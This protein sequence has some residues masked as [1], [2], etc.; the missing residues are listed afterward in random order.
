MSRRWFPWL[1]LAAILLVTALVYWPGTYGSWALDDY[2]NIVDNPA[3][4]IKHLSAGALLRA[5]LSMHSGIFARPLAMAS[6][7]LN[8]W[9]S[10]LEPGPMKVT[11]VA[12]HL[13]NGVLV[14]L[15]VRLLI[16]EYGRRRRT[17]W[18]PGTG[19]GVALLITAAWLLTPLNLTAVLYIV[20][21]MTSLAATFTL[22]ALLAYVAGRQRL[23]SG[24]GRRGGIALLLLAAI[25]LTPLSVSAKEVGA[26]TLVYALV[27]EWVFFGFRNADGRRSG[28]LFGYF[29]LF[30]VVPGLLGA[31][32][33][34]PIVFGP[35]AYA[36]RPFGL[37]E[38]LLTEGRVLWHYLWWTLFPDIGQLSLYHDA[39][40]VSR[41]LWSP[42]STLPAWIGIT[43]LLGAGLA[44][45]RRWPLVSFGILWFL[46]G[47]LLT[48]TVFPLELVFEHRQYL[49]SLGIFTS[50]FGSLMLAEPRMRL[51]LARAAGAGAIVLLYAGALALRS[52]DWS[53]PLIMTN[54][55]AKDHPHSPRATYSYA[56]V[57]AVLVERDPSLY[58]KAMRAL[59][60]AAAVPGQSTTPESTM[61]ILAHRQHEP[62]D[63]DWYAAME[64][65]LAARPP[66]AQDISAIYALV[67]CA[68]VVKNPCVLP[69]KP[70]SGIF[71]A[72][73]GH[74]P[75]NRDIQ[76]I[77]GTYLFA[78]RHDPAKA[79]TVFAGLVRQDPGN[80][81]FHYDLGI[82]AAVTGDVATAKSQ[83]HA[84]ERGNRLGMNDPQ[85]RQL[86]ELLAH[87]Q[88]RMPVA[89]PGL[90]A[91]GSRPR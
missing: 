91:A 40:P 75:R 63:P 9:A 26:L 78:V 33:Q 25:V 24:V 71:A 12:I 5:A 42:W 15:L 79:Q 62:I 68:R 45:R 18:L 6:F 8:E 69:P 35:V 31:I 64:H 27:I 38:R 14:F 1:A 21:R 55:A 17:E 53:N 65:K 32:W 28:F 60:T 43:A 49:P 3:L 76:A 10:G 30:L 81:L 88:T 39:F 51:R 29:L 19:N 59:N 72:A 66:N 4:S 61:I 11:N 41:S 52:L 82:A 80:A 89:K 73:L 20:Q 70:M 58:P 56:R 23:Y 46:A 22:A 34:L 54:I 86:S 74:R 57:L 44:L 77:Y 85:I 83:L 50:L 16:D 37:G 48:A 87:G 36:A 13:L 67:H 84:L 2:P 47:Q 7:T 90:P